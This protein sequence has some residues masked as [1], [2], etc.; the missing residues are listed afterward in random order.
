MSELSV[1]NARLA[2]W[3]N[4]TGDGNRNGIE[5]QMEVKERRIQKHHSDRISVD[6]AESA[7]APMRRAFPSCISGMVFRFFSFLVFRFSFLASF[8]VAIYIIEAVAR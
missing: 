6:D 8:L 5:M 1:P 3:G 4:E 7:S 2:D